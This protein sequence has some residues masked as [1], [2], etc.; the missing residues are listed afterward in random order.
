MLRKRAILNFESLV[1][2]NREEILN[3][4]KKLAEIEDRIDEKMHATLN[5]EQSFKMN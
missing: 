2:S 1:D 3:D 4:M 5:L